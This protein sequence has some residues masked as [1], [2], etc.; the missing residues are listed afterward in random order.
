MQ[1]GRLAMKGLAVNDW[2]QR[3]KQRKLVQWA[4]A[5]VAAAFALIQVLEV[6]ADSYAWPHAVMHAAFGV[7]ALGFLIALVLAWYHGERGEDRISG[8][9]LLL[10]ALVLA[11]GGGLLWH[12]GRSGSPAT[13]PGNAVAAARGPDAAQQNPASAVPT[14]AAGAAAPGLRTTP[15]RA[16]QPIPAKSIAVLP[17]E[18]LSNDKDNAYFV[19]GM[20]DLILTKLADIGDLKV[21]ARTST[22][23]YQSRPDDLEA[24]GRQLGVATI[25]EGSVQKA[26]DEVL[27]N[28]QLIDAKT[29]AH[30][31]AQDYQRKLADIFGVEGEVAGKI[32]VTLDAKLSPAETARLDAVPTT[33]QA[34]YDLFLRADYDANRGDTNYDTASWKA[35]I[36]LYRQA[37]ARDPGFALAY[38]RLSYV[39]SILGWFGGGGEDPG[40]L[41]AQA[42]TDAKQA[43]KLAPDFAASRIAMGYSD[44][45]GARDYDGAL[46]AFDAALAVRPNDADA[47][48]ARGYVERRQGRFGDAITSLTGALAHDPRNGSLAYEIGY[49]CMMAA[50]YADAEPWFERALALDPTNL[51]AKVWRSQAILLDSGDIAKALAAVAGDAPALEIQ[52]VSLLSMQRKDHDAIALLESVPDS[53]DVFSVGIGSKA[54]LLADLYRLSGDTA[55]ARPLFTEA[56]ATARTQLD[57]QQNLKLAGAWQHVA[58]AELGLGRTAAGLDAIGRAQA[59]VAA[60]KDQTNGPVMMKRDAAL[61]AEARRP[62]RAVPLLAK[63]LAKRGISY[64]Y[65][66][67][68]LWLD[69]TW[70][71]IRRDPGFRA[72]LAKYATYK[73]AMHQGSS[74]TP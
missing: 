71:P 64:V 11:I 5:Y 36:P 49:T 58:S 43:L 57:R 22:E 1:P 23:K 16:A 40:Q 10:I 72:L 48:A 2:L 73:P 41:T 61:Y 47:L 14:S 7:L 3:L 19:A 62:D 4:I 35:A 38:A 42:N 26:G 54:L 65:S 53:P 28:V 56:L 12:F 70:D 52:R 25:L 21:I 6:V 74:A 9:E 8:P 46:D 68:L 63:A 30:V 55:N 59:I 45:Y 60:T 44:Y 69:P 20:Q 27:I 29:D 51:N 31:W 34:A 66:P 37:I 39:E 18:N 13:A 33:D 50:R 32:A 67:L 17:F 24:I 15:V